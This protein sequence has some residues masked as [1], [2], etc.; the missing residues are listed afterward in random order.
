MRAAFAT[1][2][3]YVLL[4]IAIA[5]ATGIG[6]VALWPEGDVPKLTFIEGTPID[7]TYAAEVSS[8]QDFVCSEFGSGR[9]QKVEFKLEDGPDE[10]QTTTVDNPIGPGYRAFSEGDHLRVAKSE[11]PLGALPGTVNPYSIVDYE[12]KPP[13][14]WLALGFAA[15]VILFGRMRGAAS[16]IGLGISLLI[17]LAFVVPALLRDAPPLAVALVGSIAVMLTTIPLAHG[18]GPKSLAAIVG[19]AVS[20]LLVVGLTIVFT[21]ATHLTGAASEEAATLSANNQGIDL[22]GLLI[23]GM[24]IGALGVLDDVTISQASTVMA[25]RAANPDLAFGQLFRRAIDVGRDHVSATVNTL[26]LAY[27]GA[28][29]VT[30]LVFGSGQIGVLDAINLETIASVVV[31]TL[32]GSTGLICAVPI[33]TALASL[34]AE[35]IPAE[36]LAAEPAPVHTH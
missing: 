28:S 8:T 10:G 1:R 17:I 16:L 20:L 6:M 31:A 3:T 11:P 36:E 13:L 25:L 32:V 27:V 19:T 14:L 24:V 26:V 5:V 4:V 35:G 7:E 34:L 2:R 15:L 29:L 22:Q 30:L 9:C 21:H 23:A 12:R 33:T 18:L